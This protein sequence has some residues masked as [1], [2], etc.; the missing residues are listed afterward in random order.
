[1]TV[2]MGTSGYYYN[3]WKGIFYPEDIPK[4]DWL[5]YYARH[6]RT[7]EINNTFYKTPNKSTFEKWAERTPHDFKFTLKG[8]R[9]VTHLK[10]LNDPRE[11]L[12]NFYSAIEPLAHKTDC[13]LWQLPPNLHYD[14]EKLENFA[15]AC[16]GEY[17]NVI[18]FRHKSW[19]NEECYDVLREYKLTFCMLSTA[20]DLPEIPLQIGHTAYLRFHGKD[21]KQ[22]YRYYYS[23]AELQ[24]WAEKIR[25]L[26]P[27]RI[28]IYFNNDY[29]GNAIK[30]ARELE[31]M[32]G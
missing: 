11:G 31:G 25:E 29:D 1:M 9:Y 3:D 20:D 17:A 28:F 16:G 4:K 5:P 6:F 30:N 13:V 21:K 24:E 7:V 8:S 18:E 14:K 23:K 15:R 12:N 32:L 27:H 22:K 19:F 2:Y 26:N 10:K